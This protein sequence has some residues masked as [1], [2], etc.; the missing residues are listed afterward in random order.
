[1][2]KVGVTVGEPPVPVDRVAV[3]E[4]AETVLR[5]VPLV[6][7][8]GVVVKLDSRVTA[9]VFVVVASLITTVEVASAVFVAGT[10]VGEGRAATV[11]S[12]EDRTSKSTVACRFTL[13]AVVSGIAAGKGRQAPMSS[14]KIRNML[15]FFIKP[16]LGYD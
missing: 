5:G 4:G 8:T 2:P 10:S 6:A 1:M 9:G 15:I 11:C 14:G 16:S 3:L 13:G 12:T 7:V